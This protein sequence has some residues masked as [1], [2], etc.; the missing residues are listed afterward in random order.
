MNDGTQKDYGSPADGPANKLWD[1]VR[2]VRGG[3]DILCGP[4]A[5][6]AQTLCVNGMQESMPDITDFP[7][8][9]VQPTGDTD[10]RLRYVPGLNK[11]L[12]DCYEDMVLPSEMKSPWSRP[13]ISVDLTAYHEFPRAPELVARY[14]APIGNSL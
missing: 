14:P 10:K 3:T 11:S 5:A 12:M 9:L 4:Q 13:G 2:A 1:S 6:R 7:S 8:D